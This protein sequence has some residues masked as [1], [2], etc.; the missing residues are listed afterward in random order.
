MSGQKPIQEKGILRVSETSKYFGK[1]K[2]K[3]G[4]YTKTDSESRVC[5]K[6]Q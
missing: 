4:D 2:F 6:F 3:A 5:L 1:K